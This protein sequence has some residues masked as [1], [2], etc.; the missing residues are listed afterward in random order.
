VDPDNQMCLKLYK[1]FRKVHKVTEQGHQAIAARD[2]KRA[3][4]KLT[5]ALSLVEYKYKGIRKNI[6]N[7]LCTCYLQLKEGTHAY[8][9]CTDALNLDSHNV[10]LLMHRAEANLLNDD[11]EA[12]IRDYQQAHQ[13]DRNNPHEKITIKF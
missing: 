1:L 8:K 4:E 9:T 6:L 12:A 2:T 13:L 3:V 7:I 5:E 11:Y 10:Q